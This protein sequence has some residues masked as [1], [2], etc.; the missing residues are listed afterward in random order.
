MT[1]ITDGVIGDGAG[2]GAP[3]DA[4]YWVGAANGSLS[5]EKDLSGFT[6]L[7]KNTAGTPSAAVAG[8]DYLANDVIDRQTLGADAQ[9]ITIPVSDT[10]ERIEIEGFGDSPSADYT[11][12]VNDNATPVVYSTITQVDAAA[13]GNSSAYW[14]TTGSQPFG[15]RMVFDVKNL[16]LRRGGLVHAW[17][18]QAN[19]TR[20]QYLCAFRWPNA[21][22]NVTQII[23]RGSAAT[24]FK[25][26]FRIITRRRKMTA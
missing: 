22:D 4:Q 18:S 1:L 21:A 12:R 2:G 23:L 9:E 6:G 5:A 10:D 14:V 19:G 25:S 15:F 26:G 7:V 24:S 3:T 16:G 13:V 20:D 17:T 11:I 8:T